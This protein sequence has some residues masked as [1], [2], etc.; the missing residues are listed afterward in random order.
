MT[1]KPYIDRIVRATGLS[2]D[3]ASRALV[4]VFHGLLDAVGDRAH[5]SLTVTPGPESDSQTITNISVVI[6]IVVPPPPPNR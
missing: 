2:E 4:A 1:N 6:N 5:T 3:D